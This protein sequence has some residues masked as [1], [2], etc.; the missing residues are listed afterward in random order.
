MLAAILLYHLFNPFPITI[1][2]STHSNLPYLFQSFLKYFKKILISWNLFKLTVFNL[3]PSFNPWLIILLIYYA[4][5]Y[6][7]FSY[8]QHSRVDPISYCIWI[9]SLFQPHDHSNSFDFFDPLK[10]W[11]YLILF[12]YLLFKLDPLM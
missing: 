11:L 9:I 3:F 2:I 7:V 5:Q 1:A 12:V 8:I 4:T 6:P 10:P